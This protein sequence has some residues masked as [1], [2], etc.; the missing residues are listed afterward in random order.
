MPR[1]C[2]QELTL[3]GSGNHGRVRFEMEVLYPGIRIAE[4][5]YYAY[6]CTLKKFWAPLF[7]YETGNRRNFTV[8]MYHFIA[9][10]VDLLPSGPA[11]TSSAILIAVY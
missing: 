9:N 5:V 2:P 11:Y 4:K 10:K 6:I 3:A 8:K 1:Y 7:S